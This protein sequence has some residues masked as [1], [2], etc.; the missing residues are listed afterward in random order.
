MYEGSANWHGSPGASMALSRAISCWSKSNHQSTRSGAE[1]WSTSKPA[2]LPLPFCRL[3]LRFPRLLSHCRGTQVFTNR[4]LHSVDLCDKPAGRQTVVYGV[5][6]RLAK[7]GK[8]LLKLSNA[9][10]R[11]SQLCITSYHSLVSTISTIPRRLPSR[12]VCQNS[13][14]ACSPP[15]AAGRRSQNTLAPKYA[16]AVA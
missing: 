13:T 1:R 15:N 4:K 8:L 6:F 16:S 9:F 5:R 7:Q 12:F 2:S 10:E 3:S 11:R 14:V